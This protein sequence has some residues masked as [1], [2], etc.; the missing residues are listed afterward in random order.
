MAKGGQAFIDLGESSK[1]NRIKRFRPDWAGKQD[2]METNG[3]PRNMLPGDTKLSIKWHSGK[4]SS[5]EAGES[6]NTEGR[7][8]PIH[9]IFTYCVRANARY[10]YL[11]TDEELLA[12]RIRPMQSSRS[13]TSEDSAQ[14]AAKRARRKGL[15]EYKAIPWNVDK[16][17]TD[18]KPPRLTV[19]LALW[20]LHMMAAAGNEIQ[21][22]YEPLN[23]HL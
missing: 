11:I 23:E 6:E 22:S 4:L 16:S 5:S 12:V 1:N 18:G 7:L 13:I 17:E 19:N 2:S 9:Q 21:D 15:L 8:S 3:R 20:W 14:T 10:G